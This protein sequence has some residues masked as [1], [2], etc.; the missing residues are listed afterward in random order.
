SGR[1]LVFIQEDGTL[2]LGDFTLDR[3]ALKQFDVIVE[4]IDKSG[5]KDSTTVRVTVNDVNDNAPVFKFDSLV[6][7]VTEGSRNDTLEITASDSDSGENGEIHFQLVGGNR[8]LFLLEK[9]SPQSALLKLNGPLDHETQPKYVLTIEAK[10]GGHPPMSSTATVTVN[11]LN[12]NDSPP[13]F[14]K[15][16]YEQEVCVIVW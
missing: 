8:Q 4:A 1:E 14:K 6:W 11:V 15:V 9:T 10:D 2:I 13:I 3:E 5:N 7:N 12:R 16:N